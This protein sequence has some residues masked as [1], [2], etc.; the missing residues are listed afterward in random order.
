[1]L[2]ALLPLLEVL[3]AGGAGGAGAAGAAGAAEVAAGAGAAAGAA[4]AG[5]AANA[6]AGVGRAAG[7][8]SGAAEAAPAMTTKSGLSDLLNLLAGA[9]QSGKSTEPKAPPISDPDKRPPESARAAPSSVP[10]ARPAPPRSSPSPSPPTPK[11][12]GGGG[13]LLGDLLGSLGKGGAAGA[14]ASGE[15]PFPFPLGAPP[16]MSQTR[17]KYVQEIGGDVGEEV[18]VKM[19]EAAESFKEPLGPLKFAMKEMVELPLTIKRWG[20]SLL[21][22][23]KHL[24]AFNSKIAGAYGEAERRDI[25][26]DVESGATTSSSTESLSEAMSNFN[27][28]IQPFKDMVTNGLNTLVSTVVQGLT[29]AIQIGKTTNA[30][31]MALAAIHD[32]I[33]RKDNTELSRFGTFMEDIRD[34]KLPNK[35]TRTPPKK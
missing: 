9:P 20:D 19:I 29:I 22:S 28:E 3:L 33:Y 11:S 25:L 30:A 34:G 12:G 31:Y 8:A 18:H 10:D 26:R 35:H 23:Q 7:A 2:A 5:A 24:V 21:E 27:D 4:E 1:M 32:A 17:H 15:M 14:L 6:A 13:N 16:D